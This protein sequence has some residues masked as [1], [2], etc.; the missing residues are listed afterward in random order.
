MSSQSVLMS[1][2]K[3]TGTLHIGNYFGAI[4]QMVKLAR[5]HESYIMVADLHSLTSVHSAPTL[6][7]L[8]RELVAAYIALGLDAPN[9][10]IFQQ[11]AVKGHTDLAWIF[12][13]LSTMPYL[14]RAHAFKD[15]EAKNNEVSVGTFNYPLLMA[16]DILLYGADIVPVGKDQEQHLEIARDCARK[17]NLTFGVSTNDIVECVLKEPQAV[18]PEEVATIVGTDGRKMSKSYGNVLPLFGSTEEVLH[19]CMSVVTDS[20]GKGEPLDPDTDVLFKL[21][22]LVQTQDALIALRARY[23][24]GT[25]GYKESKELLAQTITAY[26]APMRARYVELLDPANSEIQDVLE[27]GR[28]AAQIRADATMHIVR[29]KTGLQLT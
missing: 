27:K 13:C 9:V 26:F 17:F 8:T 6:Q 4:Q 10:H 22:T 12:S 18:I 3:A 28:A 5:S 7:N 19:A 25:I 20:K 1:G 15:A 2:V 11:S 29:Q 14:M 21:H 23:T 16:A 24:E